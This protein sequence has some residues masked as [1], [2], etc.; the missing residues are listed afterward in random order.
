MHARAEVEETGASPVVV[1]PRLFRLEEVGWLANE[2]RVLRALRGYQVWIDDPDLGGAPFSR[3][4]YH[5]RLA[6]AVADIGFPS[7]G[8]SR[9]TLLYARRG[10]IS[11]SAPYWRREEAAGRG[12]VAVVFLGD[13]EINV[14]DGSDGR[15]RGVEGTAGDVALLAS[16]GARLTATTDG[17][18]APLLVV[19][20]GDGA[21]RMRGGRAVSPPTFSDDCL[22]QP[23]YWTAG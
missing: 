6:S 9:T 2:A 20:Y 17:P 10:I 15:F 8:V 21:V 5:P 19:R 11:P 12:P 23:A 18:L 16:T 3:L 4:A 7:L 1:V 22:W 14:A 13:A